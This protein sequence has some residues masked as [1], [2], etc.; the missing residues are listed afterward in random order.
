ME[1]GAKL[2]KLLLGALL[3]LPFCFCREQG[4]INFISLLHIQ[5]IYTFI[6][7]Y[8]VARIQ[9]NIAYFKNM[10]FF[11]LKFLYFLLR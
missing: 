9:I 6:G 8:S 4:K 7:Y 2:W 5:R 11:H 3:I 10:L 1:F